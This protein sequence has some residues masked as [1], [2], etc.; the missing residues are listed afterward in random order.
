MVGVVREKRPERERV[1]PIESILPPAT[2]S[3]WRSQQPS[4]VANTEDT[5]LVEIPIASLIGE[6]DGVPAVKVHRKRHSKDWA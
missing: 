2:L 3:L 4:A 1:L 5:G 6:P